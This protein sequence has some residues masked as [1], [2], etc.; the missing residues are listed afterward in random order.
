MDI[1]RHRADRTTV[2]DRHITGKD[3]AGRMGINRTVDMSGFPIGLQI[4]ET[5]KGGISA[6]PIDF[7]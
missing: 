5:T 4:W 7:C 6:P 3:M 2:G 1:G